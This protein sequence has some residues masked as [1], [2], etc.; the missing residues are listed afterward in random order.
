[1]KSYYELTRHSGN[2]DLFRAVEMSIAAS[3]NGVPFHIHAEG[4]RGTGKTSIMRAA[5]KILPQ[6]VRIK[7]CIYNCHPA[8]PHCPHH[9]ALR[10][11]KIADLGAEMIPCPFLEISHA[12]KI[13]TVVG[14]IDLG[15]LTD[16]LEPVA[17]LLPGTIP[18]A[19]RGI[20]FIDEINRL[21]DTAPELADV[22]LTVMGTKP[23]RIQIE[24]SG[25][26][27]VDMAVSVSV[28]A[29]SNPDEDPGGLTQVRRQLADRF[30]MV[31]PM[32]RPN[33]YSAVSKILQKNTVSSASSTFF[34]L[35]NPELSWQA[36]CSGESISSTLANIYVDF[37][38]ESLRAVEAL[39]GG[40]RL[41]A[42]LSGRNLVTNADLIAVAPLILGH[43]T[44]SGT[45]T[46][47]LKYLESIENLASGK[48]SEAYGDTL[49]ASQHPLLGSSDS[50]IHKETWLQKMRRFF[51]GL[52]KSRKTQK[53]MEADKKQTN[54]TPSP[55]A[56]NSMRGGPHAAPADPM[57]TNISAPE[58]PAIPLANLKP[59]QY[60]SDGDNQTHG[61]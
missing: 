53:R 33:D 2:Q 50:V 29:A 44:D 18:Q 24:E 23:G 45:I 1:M 27:I 21:A 32:G 11:D 30:D 52:L 25:L 19:H 41:N 59:E 14:S 10:P 54:E 6:I 12:A 42:L 17:A 49:K 51:N 43:R 60:V 57:K 56:D 35:Q 40:A 20:I 16:R 48:S 39:E 3:I 46:S 61:R 38:L 55:Q 5:K 15:K 34:E 37:G 8:N 7:G 36:V 4:L 58:K 47:I 22:L 28:W 13:G 31:I 26:P 9:K